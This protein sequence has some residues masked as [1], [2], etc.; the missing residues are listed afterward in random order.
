M[1]FARL[2]QVVKP[3]DRLFL[4]DGLVQLVV[5]RVAGNDVHCKVAVGGELRSKKG[6]N[7]PGID[8][9]ISAFTDHDRACLEFALKQWR[10]RGEPV[11]RGN[12]GGHRSRA[13]RRQGHRQT[14]LHHR[15]DRAL[16]RPQ[17]LRRN[18]EGG[19]RHHGGARRPRGGSADRGNGH[20]AEA[21][22]RQG[23]PR[24][25]AGH[26][27]HADARIHGVQPPAHAR[28]VHGRGQ[29]HPGRH[30]LHHALGRVG[31]GQV[32]RGSRGDAGEDRRLYGSAP[33]AH[34]A[35]RSRRRCPASTSRPRRPKRSPR[36]WNTRWRRCRAPPCLCP[37]GPAP[38]RG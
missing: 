22:H 4:N 10:G 30:R 20:P 8:L 24:G 7:L 28:R 26:H 15:Q 27:R 25:Q 36:W 6:L 13:R 34:T 32:S 38:P 14:A 35:Q 23:Q 21:A 1:S 16:G 12:G 18:P 33:A 31:D 9:G 29:R 3:G 11:V 37:P 2:P 17:T 5:E 19:G